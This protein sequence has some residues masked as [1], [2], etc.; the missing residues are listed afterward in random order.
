MWNWQLEG[1]PDFTYD[2][3]ELSK[4]ESKFLQTSGVLL[5]AFQHVNHLDQNELLIEILSEEALDTSAIEGSFLNRE[6]LQLSLM[7]NFGLNG[8]SDRIVKKHVSLA[9]QGIASLM[10]EIY[11]NYQ[12]KL[13]HQDLFEWHKMITLGRTDLEDIG[14]YRTHEDE[15]QI[16]SGF[17]H[18]PKIHFVAPPSKTM[19][20]EMDQFVNWFNKTAPNGNTA[21]PALIRAGIAH[22]YFVVIHPFEDGNGRVA[23][24]LAQKAL[25]QSID[26]PLLIAMSHT[27]KNNKKDY[28][29][30]LNASNT[31]L[32]ITDWL[33]YFANLIITTQEYTN[34]LITFIIN[35]T[36]FYDLHKDK[37]NERQAKVIEKL[38]AAGVQ[39]FTGGL[40]AENYISITR[41]ARAT[42]TRDLHD[43]VQKNIFTKTGE[44]K[45]TRYYLNLASL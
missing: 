8:I 16:V 1:W 41:A 21:L 35:K 43:L 15:M 10:T 9:E 36:K 26:K 22:L 44:L 32:D 20:K 40:S 38:F 18:K 2:Q 13:S 34:D 31:S 27:I 23:R 37:L 24:A 17:M 25:C 42:A 7:K 5:G 39:G 28:Y 3:T 29:K 12:K 6:S 33:I 45:S 4:L 14:R 30:F 11:K 19:P